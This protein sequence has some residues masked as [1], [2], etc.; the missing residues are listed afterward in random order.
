MYSGHPMVGCPGSLPT[1]PCI[2]RAL[3]AIKSTLSSDQHL[4]MTSGY[5][6]MCQS[7]AQ[8]AQHS[9]C[10]ILYAKNKQN[11][12]IMPSHPSACMLLDVFNRPNAVTHCGCEIYLC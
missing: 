2:L 11:V 10:I 12:L 8:L 4:T 5:L 6:C 3:S 7:Q 1:R 9:H